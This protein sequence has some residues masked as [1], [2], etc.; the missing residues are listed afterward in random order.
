MKWLRFLKTELVIALETS[1]HVSIAELHV[2]AHIAERVAA[3]VL[4]KQLVDA[5]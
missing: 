5:G 3:V 2:G 1:F 4:S